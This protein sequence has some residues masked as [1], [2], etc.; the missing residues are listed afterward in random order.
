MNRNDRA[1]LPNRRFAETMN[2]S[3]DGQHYIVTVGRY[4]D[5]GKVA[6]IFINS[7]MRVGSTADV[8]AVDG[9]F[10]VSLALQYGCDVETLRAGCKR[11]ADGTPQGPLGAA[12]DAIMEAV[13]LTGQLETDEHGV[14]GPKPR[15]P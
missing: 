5:S 9:A 7:S 6:E 4:P 12:L 15:V 13:P 2:F 11:N 1:R 10:A 3:V 14:L 8:N